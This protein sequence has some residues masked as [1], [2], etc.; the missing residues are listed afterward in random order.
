MSVDII[1]ILTWW[2]MLTLLGIISLPLTYW[3]FRNFTDRGVAFARTIGMLSV[4][5]IAFLGAIA[6]VIPL[7]TP[8]LWGYVVLYAGINYFVYTKVK[9]TILKDLKEQKRAII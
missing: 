2:L 7:H 6:K 1:Y 8:F 3:L 5:Y 4:S 9:D